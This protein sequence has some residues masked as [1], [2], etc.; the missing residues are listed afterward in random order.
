ML[1][2]ILTFTSYKDGYE[3]NIEN[4]FFINKS[5]D[6]IMNFFL[7][8]FTQKE[9]CKQVYNLEILKKN[10]KII[11]ICFDEDDTQKWSYTIECNLLSNDDL[12]KKFSYNL[13]KMDVDY[14]EHTF[15]DSM[16]LIVQASHKARL[17]NGTDFVSN[18]EK[19]IS[20]TNKK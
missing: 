3:N 11:C 15:I 6:H 16:P 4:L 20:E 1:I 2:T 19:Y 9:K 14:I 12:D 8:I 5:D 17:L 7:S 13:T 18:L 10:D